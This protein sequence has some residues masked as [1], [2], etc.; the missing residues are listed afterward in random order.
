[1]NRI[2]EALKLAV[3]RDNIGE[4]RHVVREN[5]SAIVAALESRT[6][7][8]A[9]NASINRPGCVPAMINRVDLAHMCFDMETP[10]A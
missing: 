7:A 9:P 8:Y 2:A 3:Q 4:I 1:M 5:L 6:D 10:D